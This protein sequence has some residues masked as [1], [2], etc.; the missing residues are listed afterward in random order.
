VTKSWIGFEYREFLN[1][2]AVP[3]GDASR[4]TVALPLETKARFQKWRENGVSLACPDAAAN[5]SRCCV[6][7]QQEIIS[8][9]KEN[10]E[11]SIK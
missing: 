11:F 10:H 8:I 1:A 6:S 7:W 3:I 9:F 5:A 2:A 4:E